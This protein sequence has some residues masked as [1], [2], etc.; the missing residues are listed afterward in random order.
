MTA[1]ASTRPVRAVDP[2][3]RLLTWNIVLDGVGS[4]VLIIGLPFVLIRYVGAPPVWVALTL[5][6]GQGIGALAAG[7]VGSWSDRAR[8]RHLLVG[9]Q[10]CQV[11]A[12]LLLM[13]A[14]GRT[15]WTASVALCVAL[16]AL[17]R[18]QNVVRDVL[19]SRCVPLEERAVFNL[20][21]R[22][23]FLV[24]NA[25]AGA[26]VVAVADRLRGEGWLLLPAVDLV[27]F[28]ACMG[29]T[30]G[31]NSRVDAPTSTI[32]LPGGRMALLIRRRPVWTLLLCLMVAGA[33]ASTIT[34]GL[35]IWVAETQK[36]GSW[37]LAPFGVAF[38]V[39]EVSAQTWLRHRAEV[40][41][42]TWRLGRYLVPTL[43]VAGVILLCAAARLPTGWALPL[44]AA[45]GAAVVVSSLI[46]MVMSVSLQFWVGDDTHR[47]VIS[48]LFRLCQGIGFALLSLLAPLPFTGPLP[49]LAAAV[50]LTATAAVLL[51]YSPGRLRVV[52]DAFQLRE[53]DLR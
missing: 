2:S 29:L 44:I 31:T 46:V 7:P 5:A 51:P 30:L 4:T 22:N 8:P 1:E 43:S 16:L 20:Q 3:A 35:G 52:R 21:V 38:L 50:G 9:F 32:D 24:A 41:S 53:A 23:Y 26:A 36:V 15:A 12:L 48:G 47:G 49:L 27:L 19:R 40:G 6:L 17:A 10:T 39:V 37:V 42:R 28:L 11:V 25:L 33:W 14:L 45:G 18:M 13:L 34:T